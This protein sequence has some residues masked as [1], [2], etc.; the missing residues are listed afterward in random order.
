VNDFTALAATSMVS[1][2]CFFAT[3][4]VAVPV[5]RRKN[6]ATT[7]LFRIPGGPVVP[8]GATVLCVWLITAATPAQ[9]LA[10]SAA[11]V[12]GTLLYASARR[13]RTA[14]PARTE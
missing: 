11:V 8:A 9:Q 12:V 7:S 10:C 5:L 3:T 6:A 2:L 14:E 1:R 13:W 4:C